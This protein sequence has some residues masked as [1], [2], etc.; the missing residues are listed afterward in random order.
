MK[1]FE[2]CEGKLLYNSFS[3][4]FMETLTLCD[5]FEGVRALNPIFEP[6]K[7]D[8]IDRQI[9]SSSLNFLSR[10]T[11]P[12]FDIYITVAESNNN[13]EPFSVKGKMY[14]NSTLFFTSTVL[15]SYR[16]VIDNI[17]DDQSS[18]N[19]SYGCKV[20]L[21]RL[22]TDQL[23]ALSGIFQDL[24]YWAYDSQ[25]GSHSIDGIKR[26]IIVNN[27]YIDDKYNVDL[28]NGVTIN[29]GTLREVQNR[30]NGLLNKNCSNVT[31]KKTSTHTFIDIWEDIDHSQQEGCDFSEIDEESIIEHIER[32]HRCDLLGIMSGYPVEWPY[33]MESSYNDICGSNIA[34]DTDDLVL[35]N[36]SYSI[37]FGTYGKRDDEDGYVDW[38]NHLAQRSRYHVSWPEY[39]TLVELALV[40]KHIIDYVWDSYSCRSDIATGDNQKMFIATIKEN[41]KLGVKLTHTILELDDVRYLRFVSH[42]HMYTMLTK[43]MGLAEQHEKL[44]GV[45]R[46]FDI[47]LTNLNNVVELE[48]SN[49]TKNIL[50]YISIASILALFLENS[51]VEVVS[52]VFSSR[53]GVWAGYII[54]VLVIALLLYIGFFF[55]KELINKSKK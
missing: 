4:V 15:M 41:A 26:G 33:R 53:L 24:E 25:S 21:D 23:I 55:M 19:G 42:R 3:M 37:V 47:A 49:K 51:E 43:N 9:F 40:N 45:I 1:N 29:S 14:V 48:Q 6:V 7:D 39:L 52:N 34:I 50:W 44:N 10:Y 32:N 11:L 17:S 18:V 16:L 8:F 5:K 31:N 2:R 22:D 13:F 36:E 35:S 20:S 30:F 54:Y 38:K 28:T 46:S 12:S 27:F